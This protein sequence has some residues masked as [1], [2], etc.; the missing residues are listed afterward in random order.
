MLKC[1]QLSIVRVVKVAALQE[2]SH[3]FGANRKV[4]KRRKGHRV[5]EEKS[6]ELWNEYQWSISM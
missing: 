5:A 6:G 1:N 4:V 2:Q 3:W